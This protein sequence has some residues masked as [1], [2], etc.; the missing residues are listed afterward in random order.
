MSQMLT[1]EFY[2]ADFVRVFHDEDINAL[3]VKYFQR[4]PSDKHFIPV[5][6][7]MLEGFKQLNTQKF[8]ADIRKMGVLG[9]D[10]QSLI[11]TKPLPGMISHLQ[12]RKLYH[13]QLID[14]GEIMAKV[15]ANNVKHKSK[16]ES[17]EIVQFIDE[18]KAMSYM[19]SVPPEASIR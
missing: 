5:V 14:P 6:N 17:V 12:G 19:M 13:V 16:N 7:A 11:I 15:T 9:I 2:S 8:M 10:S 3:C 1:K 4:V 18:R